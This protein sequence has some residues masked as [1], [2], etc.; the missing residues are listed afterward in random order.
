MI[1]GINRYREDRNQILD[2]AT[3]LAQVH[4]TQIRVWYEILNNMHNIIFMLK[5][6]SKCLEKYKL[7]NNSA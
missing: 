7:I 4:T 6:S 5:Q 2:P 3:L 1:I